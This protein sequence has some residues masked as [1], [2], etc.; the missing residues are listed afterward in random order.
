MRARRL[1]VVDE[2]VDGDQVA[3]L[4]GGQVT[5]LSAVASATLLAVG[6]EW[7]HVQAIADVVV[8]AVGPPP[9]GSPEDAIAGILT[10]LQCFELVELRA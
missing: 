3:V 1:P 9:Q 8:E 6:G 5:V 10:T 4:A 7:T 2:Y